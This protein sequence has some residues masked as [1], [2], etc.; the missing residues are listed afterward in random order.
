MQI[1]RHRRFCFDRTHSPSSTVRGAG[2]RSHHPQRPKRVLLTVC[3]QLATAEIRPNPSYVISLCLILSQ[4]AIPGFTDLCHV[5]FEF[6]LGVKVNAHHTLVG[7]VCLIQCKTC[8][9]LGVIYQGVG[10]RICDHIP[11]RKLPYIEIKETPQ[12][13]S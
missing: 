8:A 9:K 10:S 11:L 7:T 6:V 12:P 1:S 5:T 4:D 13:T 3:C 2:T